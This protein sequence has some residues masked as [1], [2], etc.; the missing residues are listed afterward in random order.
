MR[1]ATPS[2]FGADFLISECLLIV[3]KSSA[4]EFA[5][6]F[7]VAMPRRSPF[8]KVVPIC[9]NSATSSEDKLL[10]LK[11]PLQFD[12]MIFENMCVAS[13]DLLPYA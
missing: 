6:I 11:P 9:T 12:F 5:T 4:T 13:I 1:Y 10:S 8:T 7:S 3:A 2:T